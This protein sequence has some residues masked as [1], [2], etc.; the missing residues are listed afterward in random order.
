MSA[1]QNNTPAAAVNRWINSKSLAGLFDGSGGYIFTLVLMCVALGFRFLLAT[2]DEGLQYITFFPAVAIAAVRGGLKQGMVAVF[3]G[4]GFATYFFTAPYHSLTLESVFTS[5]WS[6]VVFLVD[7]IIVCYSIESMH[8]FRNQY[9]KELEES[10]RS[11]DR[12]KLINKE[13]DEFAY[14]ASH[15]LKEPLRGINNYASFLEEDYAHLIDEDG[16]QY[17]HAIKRLSL[18]T[19]TLIEKLLAYSRLGVSVIKE[20]LVD[21]DLIFDEVTRDMYG[22]HIQGITVKR[23][24]PLGMTTGD[25]S[26]IAE[27]LQNLISNGL[28]YNDKPEKRIEIGCEASKNTP[29]YYVSD[30]GIGIPEKHIDNVFRI[31][32]RLHEQTKFGG[33]SGAG[34]TIVKKIIERHGGR[35]W[36]ESEPGAGTTFFFTLK[37]EQMND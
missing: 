5:F 18:R 16:N 15:D 3:I 36:I 4:M 27:V 7:G 17:I 33:G 32:K 1:T 25:P 23:N 10:K 11:E 22:P 28:K 29:V 6:N 24:S 21:L 19:T 20:D 37:P 12:V 35:I 2:E 14:I 26:C 30:N 13:L 8:R 34:L 31:F 9:A